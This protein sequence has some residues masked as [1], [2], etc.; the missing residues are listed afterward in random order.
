[1]YP[2]TDNRTEKEKEFVETRNLEWEIKLKS[3]EQPTPEQ[4]THALL[5][6]IRAH[7]HS[8]RKM[9]VFF[10]VLAIIGLVVEALAIFARS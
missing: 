1:M 3:G 6:D 10:T 5:M 7:T 2:L 9:L 8:I 4:I